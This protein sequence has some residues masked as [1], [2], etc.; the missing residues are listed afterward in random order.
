VPA[1]APLPAFDGPKPPPRPEGLVPEGAT[2]APAETLPEPA[3]ENPEAEVAET[4]A[5]IVEGAADPLAGATARA[6]AV[7]S[8]PDARPR[9]FARLVERQ[10]ER[11]ARA[12]GGAREQSAAA[13]LGTPEE[14]AET[15]AEEVEVAAAAPSGDVPRSVAE[16]A[17][18]E[19]V[20]ALR[21][22]NLIGVYGTPNDRRALVRM[23]NGR[24]LRVSV[25][26]SLDGGRVA[27]ISDTALSYVRRGRTITIEIPGG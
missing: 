12:T 24:Y 27:A 16:A 3:P 19:N 18:M 17:T 11:L 13:S 14:A 25:G 15:G 1:A 2:S 7:V 4:L 23:E 10:T 22:I 6:V 5:S 8:R 26:D 20:M 9:N 21:E